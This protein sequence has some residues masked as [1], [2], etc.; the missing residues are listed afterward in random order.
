MRRIVSMPR[1]MVLLWACSVLPAGAETDAVNEKIHALKRQGY[2]HFQITRRLLSSDIDAYAPFGN[3]LHVEMTNDSGDVL[4]SSNRQISSGE[5]AREV[6]NI[7]A[8]IAQ[9]RPKAAKDSILSTLTGMWA[10]QDDTGPRKSGQSSLNELGYEK[11]D[12]A[13]NDT[14]GPDKDRDN[15]AD[16]DGNDDGHDS[17]NGGHDS[18][19]DDDHD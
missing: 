13:S 3:H 15:H 4:K 11:D 18:D 16:R 5:Y 17:D 6:A 19:S 8:L 9:K 12:D 7:R 10:Q 2:T 1:I 14:D